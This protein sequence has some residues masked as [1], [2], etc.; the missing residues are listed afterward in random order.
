MRCLVGVLRISTGEIDLSSSEPNGS[1]HVAI[2]GPLGSLITC[3]PARVTVSEARS[4]LEQARDHG[5]L[6]P[7]P[8]VIPDAA[9]LAGQGPLRLV[10]D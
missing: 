10:V 8:H 3:F 5:V 7:F 6:P 9:A 2:D 1:F 4:V